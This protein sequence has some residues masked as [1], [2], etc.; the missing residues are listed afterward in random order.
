[1]KN[2]LS[3]AV[4]MG[5][6]ASPALAGFASG[7]ATPA[8]EPEVMAEKAPTLKSCHAYCNYAPGMFGKN[9]ASGST[10]RANCPADSVAQGGSVV[11]ELVD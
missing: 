2:V 7:P 5:L 10:I 9:M 1:M 6:F 4:A 11:Y 8:K 3:L